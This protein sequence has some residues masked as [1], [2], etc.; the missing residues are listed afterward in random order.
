MVNCILISVTN[1]ASSNYE[2]KITDIKWFILFC[3]KALVWYA[4]LYS[5]ALLLL[6][7]SPKYSSALATMMKEEPLFN[8]IYL[9]EVKSFKW[10][11]VNS[12]GSALVFSYVQPRC[13]KPKCLFA[14]G[15]PIAYPA[16]IIQVKLA[17]VC[18]SHC[19]QTSCS[20][21]SEQLHGV[22]SFMVKNTQKY[23]TTPCP[24]HPNLFYPHLFM[25]FLIVHE[26]VHPSICYFK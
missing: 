22:T 11:I 1:L 19:P 5:S 17:A 10:E 21:G 2:N 18:T 24:L 7:K 20:W 6:P 23:Y 3:C 13:W 25:D 9:K 16:D 8:K 15:S 14:V 4:L 26:I 12:S